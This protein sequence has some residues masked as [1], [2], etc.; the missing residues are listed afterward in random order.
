[1]DQSS[2][3]HKYTFGIDALNSKSRADQIK[4]ILRKSLENVPGGQKIEADS[5]RR[6]LTLLSSEPLDIAPIKTALQPYGFHLRELKD[7]QIVQAHQEV[8][9]NHELKITKVCVEGMTCHSCEV[10]VERKWKKLDGVSSVEVHATTGR[11]KITHNGAAPSI[12]QLQDAL[13]EGKYIVSLNGTG[14]KTTKPSFFQLVGLFAL[15]LILGKI[16]SSFG[17]LNTNFSVGAGMSLGAI[18]VIGLVAAS[19]SCIAVSGGLLLSS[20]AKFNERYGSASPMG[21]MRPV[22]LFVLGR[23]LGYGLL[24]GLLGV[25]GKA[26]APSPIVTAFIAILAAVYMIVMGLDM[27]QIAPAWLKGLMPKMPKALSHRVMDAEGKEHPLMPVGL[28]AATFFLPCGFTQ[29]LQLYALTTGS[30]TTAALS[31][32]AFALGTAPA[33][34]AL[35]WASSSL[36]GKAGRF[37]FKFS[38]ALVVTLGL[39]NIQNGLAI[40]GYPISFP[41]FEVSSPSLAAGTVNATDLAPIVDGKQVIKMA[42][43]GGYQPNHFTIRAGTPVRWEV[44]ATNG[45]GCLSVLVSRPLGIQKLLDQSPNNVIEFTPTTAG[46][47]PFSCSMGMYRG[48]ITVL[49]AA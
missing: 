28:G 12:A 15:V 24:G 20:A 11:A 40:A 39:W 44:D 29:A 19:S 23:V 49:P 2:L 47:V 7:V 3:S 48:S 14:H 16:L 34:L 18:F 43:S 35:G 5:E 22:F 32:G 27:L 9:P 33:L 42:V 37:F 10:I 31:L 38:G 21:R 36:K 1:M 4:D 26:L 8:A 17:L 46:E 30:F 41:K 45:G 25:I 6:V 13:G